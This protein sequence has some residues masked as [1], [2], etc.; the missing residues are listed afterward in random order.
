MP[1]IGDGNIRRNELNLENMVSTAEIVE[2]LRSSGE[3][4]GRSVHQLSISAVKR[5]GFN[6]VFE[7]T[8]GSFWDKSILQ[9]I[10]PSLDM[11]Y[12]RSDKPIEVRITPKDKAKYE[13]VKSIDA[14]LSKI[15]QKL[16][17]II[18]LLM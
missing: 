7:T 6:P 14:R 5:L 13:S 4:R 12:P 1:S 16:N 9:E 3:F 15:E 8:R 2:H 17:K 11:H 10:I 18:K